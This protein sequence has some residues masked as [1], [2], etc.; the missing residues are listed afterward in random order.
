MG[1]PDIPSAPHTPEWK[2]LQV[3]CDSVFILILHVSQSE[4]QILFNKSFVQSMFADMH[5]WNT[6]SLKHEKNIFQL[7]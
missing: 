2:F 3:L 4:C 1:I 7:R 6:F 5:F